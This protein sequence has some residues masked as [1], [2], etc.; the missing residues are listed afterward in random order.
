MLRLLGRLRVGR[1]DL[2]RAHVQEVGACEG[3]ACFGDFV[4]SCK[5]DSSEEV[6]ECEV[7]AVGLGVGGSGSEGFVVGV[8]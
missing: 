1:H 4:G 3:F 5:I 6:L 7:K 8:R 2:S